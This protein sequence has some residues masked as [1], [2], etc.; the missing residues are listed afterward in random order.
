MSKNTHSNEGAVSEAKPNAD[1]ESTETKNCAG[2]PNR[3]I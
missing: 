3:K 2:Q 1:K